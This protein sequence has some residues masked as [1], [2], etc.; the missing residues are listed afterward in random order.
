[1]INNNQSGTFSITIIEFYYPKF[2]LFKTLF[3]FKDFKIVLQNNI[4]RF[5]HAWFCQFP[6][7]QKMI[8]VHFATGS[9]HITQMSEFMTHNH[10]WWT[11]ESSFFFFFGDPHFV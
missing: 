3:V 5:C 8:L 6:P 11:S 7:N 9:T 10:S 2:L 1:M 4:G